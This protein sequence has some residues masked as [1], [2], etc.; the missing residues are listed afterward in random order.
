VVRSLAIIAIAITT[1]TSTIG[2]V[3]GGGS[4]WFDSEVDVLPQGPIYPDAQS[5]M[6]YSDGWSLTPGD[7]HLQGMLCYYSWQPDSQTW[8]IQS[9]TNY[10]VI[11]G[12]DMTGTDERI[13]FSVFFH[14]QTAGTWRIAH[15]TPDYGL[16][17]A[18]ARS[19]MWT[20]SMTGGNMQD[21]TQAVYAILGV[22]LCLGM[23]VALRR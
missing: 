3:T 16:T 15:G 19:N 23:M 20:I 17:L 5:G 14:V 10:V 21:I 8:E 18:G 4:I 2:A 9:G 6:P 11:Y 12:G 7:W 22:I 13:P 1:A